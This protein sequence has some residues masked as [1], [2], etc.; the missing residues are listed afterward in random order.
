M[1]L[2]YEVFEKYSKAR[3]KEERI[4]VLKDNESWWLKDIIRGT[5]DDTVRWNL[6][7][8]APPYTE[9]KP[10][11]APSQLSKQHKK[12]V[13]FVVGGPGDN[14]NGI[15]RERL[16]IEI[17]EAIHP[18]DAKLVIAMISKKK[19]VKKLTRPIVNEAFPGLLKD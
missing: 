1:K 17:L 18:E 12:F 8:G 11:S 10:E 6:P 16:F 4:A 5:M 19:T 14:M 3:S 13:N 7:A 2:V 15:R 9:N